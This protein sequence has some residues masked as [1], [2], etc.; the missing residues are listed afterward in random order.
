MAGTTWA[1]PPNPK[2]LIRI[3]EDFANGDAPPPPPAPAYPSGKDQTKPKPSAGDARSQNGNSIRRA[4]ELGPPIPGSGITPV[5][6]LP[7]NPTAPA[8]GKENARPDLSRTINIA[9]PYQ[10]REPP[11]SSIPPVTT[12]VPPD[13]RPSTVAEPAAVPSCILTGN[14]LENFALNDLD[15][16]TWEFRKHHGRLVL[17]DFWGTWCGPCLAAI[18]ELNSLHHKYGRYG[19]EVV[20]IAYERGALEQQIMNV[21][22]VRS[23]HQF[24]YTVLLG[25]GL[26]ADCPVRDQFKVAAYPTLI[27]L[28]ENGQILWRSEGLQEPQRQQLENLIRQRLGI[29]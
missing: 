3:S 25:S 20:G 18:K 4:A 27:L 13:N 24:H 16:K 29:R 23:R 14:K 11:T 7:P 10:P 12:V 15:G 5:Q 22:A 6:I 2:V 19:L 28:D 26:E 9:N 21:R 8:A 1:T 17:V